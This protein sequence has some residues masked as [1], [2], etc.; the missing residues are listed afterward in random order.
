MRSTRLLGVLVVQTLGC[1]GASLATDASFDAG[2]PVSIDAPEAVR[3]APGLDAV[4]S[5]SDALPDAST[6][7]P[8]VPELAPDPE[9]L[10]LLDELPAG[11]S[12]LLPPLRTHG[13]WNEVTRAHRMHERGPNGRD[14]TNK[15][16]WMPDRARAFFCGANHGSPHRLNDAWEH[17]LPS[18]TWVMLFAP[19][20]NN[21]E[22]VMEIREGVIRDGEGAELE[23]VHYVSTERGGPTHYGHT[24]WGLAY[25][26]TMGAALWMNVPIA[27]RAGANTVAYMEA[28]LG[29]DAPIYRGPPLWAFYPREARWELVLSSSPWPR[30]PYAGAMEYV[31]ELG[32]AFWYAAA[33]NGSGMHVYDAADNAWTDLAP[34]GGTSLYHS[35]DA[36]RAESVMCV[37]RA[38]GIVVAQS[39]DRRTYHYELATNAW[40]RVLSPEDEAVAPEGHDARAQMYFDPASGECLLYETRRP[41]GLWSYDAG[42]RVW[43]R[44]VPEGPPVP[45]T[46]RVISYVDEAR[47]VFVISVGVNTWVYR[48]RRA[49]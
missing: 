31:P 13:E 22:G 36:P 26:P 23:R 34:N 18:N 15:A 10:A 42:A 39:P 5:G 8:I 49:D 16:V 11:S 32:G 6:P 37:D 19:D 17:D 38:R 29:E 43:T 35:A 20:P 45:D 46:G 1:E 2:A 9:I 24:W 12:A 27:S 14:Y 41:D 4:A 44:I 47:N 33:W 25:D 21:A 7:A 3:D 28:A 30:T 40:S 48:H